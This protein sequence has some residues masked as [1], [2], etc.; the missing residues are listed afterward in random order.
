MRNSLFFDG[1]M[2]LCNWG[3]CLLELNK[4]FPYFPNTAKTKERAN[5]SHQIWALQ[6]EQHSRPCKT[7]H[8]AIDHG[9]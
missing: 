9:C 2:S 5:T 8:V 7:S 4:D 6:A 3:E 1:K